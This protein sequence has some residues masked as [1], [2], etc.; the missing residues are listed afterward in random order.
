MAVV[1]RAARGMRPDARCVRGARA[2]RGVRFRLLLP[3]STTTHAAAGRAP[4]RVRKAARAAASRSAACSVLFAR[5]TKAGDGAIQGG[6]RHG[7][8]GM[9]LVPPGDV[10]V[11]RGVG[12]RIQAGAQ[13]VPVVLIEAWRT[14]WCE[15]RSRARRA[16]PAFDAGQTDGEGRGHRTVGHPLLD[17]GN[18]SFT[19]VKSTCAH[20]DS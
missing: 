5:P 16:S 11:A 2:Y 13:H 20:T 15:G 12:R 18:D 19:R 1:A 17:G 6:A 9:L 3:S 14:A 4:R 8:V 7:A 10:G